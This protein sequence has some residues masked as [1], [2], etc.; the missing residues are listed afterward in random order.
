[1]VDIWL[2]GIAG[3][4]LVGFFSREKPSIRSLYVSGLSPEVQPE[5][6]KL[7]RGAEILRKPF[8][9]E[10]LVSAVQRALEGLEV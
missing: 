2:P 10:E 3:P 1:V 6:K 4:E 5:F 9:S 7:T 8:T